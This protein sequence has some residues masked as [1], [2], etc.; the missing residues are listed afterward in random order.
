MSEEA[1]ETTQLLHNSRSETAA[2]P[3]WLKCRY[4]FCLMS[5]LGFVN[6]YAMRVNLSVAIVAMVNNTAIATNVTYNNDTC[7]DLEPRPRSNTTQPSGDGPFDWNAEEQG[8]IL[9]AFF[10]GYIVT[11]VPGGRMAEIWG[12]KWLYGTGVLVT[13]LFT[14]ITPLAAYSGVGV[15]TAVR[16]LEGLGEGVTFPAM[17]AMLSKWAPPNERSRLSSWVYSGASLGSVISMPASGYLCDT[18]GWESVFYFFGVL[19]LIWFVAWAWIVTDSPQSHPTIS[20]AEKEY[21]SKCIG[22]GHSQEAPPVPWRHILTSVPMW[23]LVFTHIAQNWGFYTLLT[24]LPTYM[25]NILHFDIKDNA[26]ISALP[27]LLSTILSFIASPVADYFID[28]RIMKRSVTR[29][30]FNSLGF[31]LPAVFLVLA[32]YSGCDVDS[33]IVFLALAGGTNSLHYSGLM[34]THLDMSPNFAGTLLGI[35]NG[36]AN[37]MGFLAP[38]FTGYIINENEDLGHWRFVFF[39]ASIVYFSGNMIY[40]G[41]GSTKEQPWN[42]FHLLN[43][44]A[45]GSADDDDANGQHHR[46]RR[47]SDNIDASRNT[48][49]RVPPVRATLMYIQTRGYDPLSGMSELEDYFLYY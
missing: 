30:L 41:F 46:N 7:P 34:S 2:E 13:S 16:I 40:I 36:F 5:F 25:K 28:H 23:A 14:L 38:A 9:G 26:A 35:T 24:E 32:G 22:S 11:Q 47:L 8:L 31:C 17:H 20:R 18:Y 44:P 1:N 3:R 21:I 27:Y 10:Y 37:V 15:F 4:V 33:T 49:R 12:G 29:K 42:N 48:A 43:Q 39:V 6:V 45:D 19:G